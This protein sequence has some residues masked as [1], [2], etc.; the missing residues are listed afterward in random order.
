V[1]DL[2]PF[3][4]DARCRVRWTSRFGLTSADDT[5]VV[6]PGEALSP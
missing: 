3:R 2:L 1:L 4:R 5:K 6:P